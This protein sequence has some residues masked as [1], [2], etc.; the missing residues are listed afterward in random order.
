MTGSQ[1]LVGAGGVALV[2]ANF[3]FGPSKKTVSAGLFGNGDPATAH[4]GLAGMAGQMV[5]VIVA[6]I[7]AGLSDTWAT[8]MTLV[9]VGL[10]ILW[11]INH[12]TK[13]ST[14]TSPG[15]TP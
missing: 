14:S 6:T 15:G 11:A 8:V 9:I 12:Y 3:W 5:F 7:L 10:A 13:S 2:A 4:K 1:T